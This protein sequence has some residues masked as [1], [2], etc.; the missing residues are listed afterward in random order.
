MFRKG[1]AEEKPLL[2]SFGKNKG[3]TPSPSE[4][5]GYFNQTLRQRIMFL[6][7]GMGTRIQAER[8]SEADYRGDLFPNP[9]KELK[10]NNDLLCLTRPALVQQI[11]EE[12]LRAGAEII[13]TNTFNGTSISQLEYDIGRK[14]IF[15]SP[16]TP[17]T[18][19]DKKRGF[20]LKQSPS[21]EQR[22]RGATLKS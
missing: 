3:A 9:P 4:V 19:N 22:K 21:T 15:L 14:F 8:L 12:Y 16:P 13:E 5:W 11:Y 20:L 7:G 17:S 18:R 1:F 10:G 6:D 2:F